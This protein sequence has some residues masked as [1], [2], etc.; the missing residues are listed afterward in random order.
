[1]QATKDFVKW[2]TAFSFV[3]WPHTIKHSKL[4]G[5]VSFGQKKSHLTKFHSQKQKKGKLFA[6]IFLHSHILRQQGE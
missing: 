5:S 1:M 6:P 2:P 4:E 3:A